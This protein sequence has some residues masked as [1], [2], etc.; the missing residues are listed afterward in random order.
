MSRYL[1]F[2]SFKGQDITPSIVPTGDYDR[3]TGL[4]VDGSNQVTSVV[5]GNASYTSILY[6]VVG[7]ITSY[8]ETING[9][10]KNYVLDYDAQFKLT[11]IN[12]V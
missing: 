6:N 9:L 4:T 1:G 8:T 11:S 2:T 7:L 12:E 10:S 3:S 5:L